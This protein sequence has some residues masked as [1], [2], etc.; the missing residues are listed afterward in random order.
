MQTDGLLVL[1][2]SQ[3]PD[4]DELYVLTSQ[5]KSLEAALAGALRREQAAESSLKKSAAEMEH[6][7]RLVGL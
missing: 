4:I 1:I 6:L 3:S 2:T 5:I 7:T